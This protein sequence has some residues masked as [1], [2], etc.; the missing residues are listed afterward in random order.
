M[1][2]QVILHKCDLCGQVFNSIDECLICEEKGLVQIEPFKIDAEINV[3]TQLFVTESLKSPDD[4]IYRNTF[5][6]AILF[7]VKL[8][9]MKIVFHE[10]LNKH[11]YLYKCEIVE[12]PS[13]LIGLYVLGYLLEDGSFPVKPITSFDKN[14]NSEIDKLFG[15]LVLLTK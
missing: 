11:T 6:R 14:L 3:Y 1:P 15:N 2:T 13:F 8:L 7:K 5:N 4:Q 10:I 9:D 12:G